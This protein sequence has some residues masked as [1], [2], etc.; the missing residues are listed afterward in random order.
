MS[1]IKIFFDT[2]VLVYAHDKSASYHTNSAEL[3]KMAVE[4]KIQGVIA[5]Q[6]MIEL[7]RILTNPTAM[8]GNA[9]TPSQARDLINGTYL[10]GTFEVI[11]PIRSTLDRA[12]QLA[13][14]GNFVSARIFDIRLAALILDANIDYF[15]TYNVSDFQGITGLNPLTPE[16][17]MAF[18]QT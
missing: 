18:L 4:T 10:G 13:V 7:Y 8:K 9:L 3:L 16:Q 11:Y 12:L 15:A 17:I 14:N 1:Q 6:N 2:N 5:E